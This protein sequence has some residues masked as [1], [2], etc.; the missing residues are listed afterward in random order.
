MHSFGSE[1]L[2]LC[3]PNLKRPNFSCFAKIN[4]TLVTKGD[5]DIFFASVNITFHTPMNLDIRLLKHKLLYNI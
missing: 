4:Q 5:D 3:C 1:Q 2:I